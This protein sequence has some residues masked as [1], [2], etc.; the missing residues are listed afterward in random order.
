M[1]DSDRPNFVVLIADDHRYES[2]SAN[3]NDVVR[4]PN[5][6]ALA[7]RGS[8]FDGAHCQGGM[9]GAV[10]VPSRASLM[11]GRSIFASTMDPTGRDLPRA[12]AIPPGMATF[13]QALREAGYDSYAVG[14]WHNDAASFARSFSDCG[15]VM[16]G[17]MSDHHR[18]PLRRFDPTGRYPD[19]EVTIGDGFSTDIFTDAAV[20]YL[21]RDNDGGPFCLYVAFTAPHDPRT[22]PDG[23]QVDPRSIA[24]PPNVAPIHPFDNGWMTGRDERLAGWPRHDDEIRQHVADYYGM[25]AH[26]DA[27]VGRVIAALERT[28]KAGKTV[29]IYTADHGLALGQHGLMGKQNLYEH[30]LRIPL[31]LA[32]PGIPR[33]ARSP[34]LVWHGDT[35]VAI[36]SLAGLAADR[37]LEGADL[38]AVL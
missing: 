26:L 36:R 3:G 27:A 7:A 30:S 10:C 2:I 37:A 19:N 34:A 15:P 21:D 13:P 20:D 16:F 35:T 22:P 25:I 1:S 31:I 29:V 14:K 18:V 23:Y 5:L 28:R 8:S 9:H 32:G 6:D 33:G 11:T 24:L 17:G 12:L 38:A 4:T